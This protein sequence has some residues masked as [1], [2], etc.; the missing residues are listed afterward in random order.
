MQPGLGSGMGVVFILHGLG[1][2]NPSFQIENP[3]SIRAAKRQPFELQNYT[4][5][6]PAISKDA[7]LDQARTTI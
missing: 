2:S 1:E 4:G 3:N 7:W 5:S 6:W